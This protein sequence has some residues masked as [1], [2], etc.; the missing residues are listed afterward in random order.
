VNSPVTASFTVTVQGAL[1]QLQSLLAYTS[2][3]G[4]GNSLTAKVQGVMKDEQA[5]DLAA[6]CS[7]L[8]AL[9]KQAMA[10]SGKQLTVTQANAIVAAAMQI[11]FVLGC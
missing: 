2:G 3:I 5:N 9:I 1:S 6:A 7:D 10:Q 4:P 11:Q 8:T